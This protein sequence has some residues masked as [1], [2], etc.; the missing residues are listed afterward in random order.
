[1]W[2]LL[3][4][5][6]SLPL[7]GML[8]ALAATV[9]SRSAAAATMGGCGGGCG[10]L[11]FGGRCFTK[12]PIPV[13]VLQSMKRY[14]HAHEHVLYCVTYTAQESQHTLYMYHQY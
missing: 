13:F 14:M 9:R 2:H 5:R 8:A 6:T 1:M 10:Y 12:Y 3:L 4:P 7:R 11:W